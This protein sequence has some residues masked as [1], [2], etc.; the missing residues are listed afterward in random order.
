MPIVTS[1]Q[2]KPDLALDLATV[3]NNLRRLDTVIADLYDTGTEL[4]V[5]PELSY[6][7]YNYL[8]PEQAWPVSS[9]ADSGSGFTYFSHLSKTLDAFTVYGFIEC[10]GEY[11]Y[12]SANLIGP[13]GSLV[14]TYR[15]SNLWGNDFLWATSGGPRGPVVNTPIGS[16]LVLICNDLT[17]N[18]STIDGTLPVPNI[19]ASPCN[20]NSPDFP[21]ENWMMMNRHSGSV[22][23]ISN[24]WG[25]ESNEGKELDFGQGG[26]CIIDRHSGVHIDGLLWGQDCTIT[27]RV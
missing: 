15:K 8:R 24:R 12:N 10:S 27:R 19:V 2:F 7:G 25:Q 26:S 18:I 11:L 23:I 5:F 22:C 13:D 20:W 21:N 4:V 6:C 17:K 9:P 14:C 3:K 16:L 1:V